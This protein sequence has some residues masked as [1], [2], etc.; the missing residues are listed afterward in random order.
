MWEGE[1]AQVLQRPLKPGGVLVID[2]FHRDATRDL[3]I[4][5]A[6][7]F[8]TISPTAGYPLRGA[9]HRCG[10]RS[11]KSAPGEVLRRAAG[12]TLSM[13]LPSGLCSRFS[14]EIR[15]TTTA[16]LPLRCS[17]CPFDASRV[18]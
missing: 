8:D 18:P 17:G 16:T 12:V 6:R 5:S 10:F 4:G 9:R 2:A 3:T 15:L 1:M 14:T 7:V 13:H 11:G